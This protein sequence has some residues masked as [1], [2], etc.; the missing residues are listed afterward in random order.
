MV[1][2]T[3]GEMPHPQTVYVP[4]PLAF[5]DPGLLAGRNLIPYQSP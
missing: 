1:G 2:P 5:L 4:S 3:R